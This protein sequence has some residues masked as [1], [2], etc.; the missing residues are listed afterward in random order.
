MTR[1]EFDNL[2]DKS[3]ARQRAKPASRPQENAIDL[4]SLTRDDVAES[5]FDFFRLKTRRIQASRAHPIAVHADRE[6]WSLLDMQ[7]RAAVTSSDF[8]NL[9]ADGL[10]TLVQGAYLAADELRGVVRD[11][12]VRDFRPVNIGSMDFGPASEVGE[13]VPLPKLGFTVREASRKGALRE[14]G[15]SVGFSR[16]T[17]SVYSD[18]IPAAFTDHAALTLPAVERSL[19]ATALEGAACPNVATALT[20]AGLDALCNLLRNAANASSQILNLSGQTLILPAELETSARVLIQAVWPTLNLLVIPELSSAT[21]YWLCCDPR[22]SA[23][24]TRL[25]LRGGNTPT[26]YRS[27]DENGNYRLALRLETDV[28]YT[29]QPGLVRG[30]A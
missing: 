21:R 13:D 23:P 9:I 24:L 19:L 27:T 3:I 18:E 12:R 5:L 17:L 22:R 25:R 30:G 20:V 28:L 6:Q 14:F 4:D 26:V 10:A 8:S 7:E 29:G 11:V 15:G 16:Q 1:E 2:L